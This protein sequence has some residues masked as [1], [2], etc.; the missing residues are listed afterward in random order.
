M[1]YAYVMTHNQTGLKYFGMTTVDNWKKVYSGS[2]KYWKRHLKAHGSNI[3]K[4]EVFATDDEE[5]FQLACEEFSDKHDIVHSDHWANLKIE[6]GCRGGS[7]K[8]IPKPGLI[9]KKRS[10]ETLKKMKK[11][12]AGLSNPRARLADIYCYKTDEIIYRDVCIAVFAKEMG[13]HA[14]SLNGTAN[15]KREH[16]KQIYARYK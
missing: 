15:G 9:G 14:S 1:N 16:Y 13:Y 6:D 10:A 12:N 2:G 3:T 11:N 5:L 4:E 8:G 7:T